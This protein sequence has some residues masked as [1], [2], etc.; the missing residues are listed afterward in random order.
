MQQQRCSIYLHADDASCEELLIVAELYSKDR[1][2]VA[3]R[4]SQQVCASDEVATI[5]VRDPQAPVC[6]QKQLTMHG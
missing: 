2:C 5:E 1:V 3:V 4:Q 6:M